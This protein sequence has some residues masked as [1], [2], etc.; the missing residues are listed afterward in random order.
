MTIIQKANEATANPARA[1]L[2]DEFSVFKSF[3]KDYEMFLL[4]YD[5]LTQKQVNFC[6]TLLKR[7]MERLYGSEW[8]DQEKREELQHS[9]ARFLLITEEPVH[10]LK[11]RKAESGDRISNLVGFVHFRFL[12]EEECEVL[13]VY[14]MQLARQVQ[15]IGLGTFLVDALEYLGQRFHMKG[16]MLTC[17][18]HNRKAMRFYEEN[19]FSISCITPRLCDIWTEP[20]YWNYEILDMMWSDSGREILKSRQAKA[21]RNILWMHKVVRG[22]ITHLSDGRKLKVLPGGIITIDPQEPKHSDGTTK[23]S[24]KRDGDAPHDDDSQ[25]GRSDELPGGAT[26]SNDSLTEEA[27]AAISVAGHKG[28]C[29]RS[30]GKIH[31]NSK[32]HL[33]WDQS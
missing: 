8:D 22:E 29:V 12:L 3:D 9:D 11:R 7:N 1:E 5:H 33:W 21:R 19:G 15:G 10:P 25:N 27:L 23:N 32:H 4:P 18:K 30:S 26:T 20:S 13:Y 28:I 14:E 31:A 2:G 6:F 16:L 17:F 24:L